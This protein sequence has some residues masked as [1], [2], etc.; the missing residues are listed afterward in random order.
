MILLDRVLDIDLLLLLNLIE[1]I[2]LAQLFFDKVGILRFLNIL[3]L[4]F[5]NF[6]FIFFLTIVVLFYFCDYRICKAGAS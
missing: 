2:S 6:I 3:S 5:F 4:S 1:I